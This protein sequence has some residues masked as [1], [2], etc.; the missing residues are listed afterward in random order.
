MDGSV[1]VGAPLLV[2]R[3]C[4]DPMFSISNW[5][6]YGGHM[7]RATKDRPSIIRDVLD[8]SRWIHV[9]GGYQT[10]WCPEEGEQVVDMLKELVDAE[11]ER[12][13]VFCITPFRVVAQQLRERIRREAGLLAGLAE[14]PHRWLYDRVGTVRTFQGKKAEAVFLVLG[15]QG[16]SHGWARQ[17]AGTPANLVNVAVSRSKQALYVVGN[18]ELWSG[19]GSFSEISRKVK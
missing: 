13:D 18:R 2:H 6:S 3:R 10:K 8:P 5:A 17:W 14:E 19:V 11:V 4:E 9:E 12:P 7:V 16:N 1:R 15:A